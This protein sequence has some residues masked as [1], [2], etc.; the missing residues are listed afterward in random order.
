MGNSVQLSSDNMAG[1]RHLCVLI[2]LAAVCIENG[3]ARV[4]RHGKSACNMFRMSISCKANEYIIPRTVRYGN[5]I[6]A[7]FWYPV[8]WWRETP[9][10]A[11]NAWHHFKKCY[12]KTSCVLD[13]RKMSSYTR[14][15][16]NQWHCLWPKWDCKRKYWGSNKCCS[17]LKTRVGSG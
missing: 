12:K 9:K 8:V 10:C 14:H 17:L 16:A 11:W 4:P 7:L 13:A 5:R 15:C 6:W 2:L 3:L 1:V